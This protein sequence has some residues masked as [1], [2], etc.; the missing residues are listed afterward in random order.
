MPYFCLWV[1][2]PRN[3]QLQTDHGTCCFVLRGRQ[4]M[5]GGVRETSLYIYGALFRFLKMVEG[6]NSEQH[7]KIVVSLQTNKLEKTPIV[8]FTKR[9]KILHL[10]VSFLWSKHISSRLLGV[11]CVDRKLGCIGTQN[12]TWCF[13][14]H[15]L[16]LE[17]ILGHKNEL[18]LITPC[19]SLISEQRWWLKRTDKNKETKKVRERKRK[20]WNK[21]LGSQCRLRSC[22]EERFLLFHQPL[23]SQPQCLHSGLVYPPNC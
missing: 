20:E 10:C 15:D 9:K 12:S 6:L 3:L 14:E 23:M 19:F 18:L 1:P 11:W 2:Q 13:F 21:F 5:G 22:G 17:Y 16:R 4:G 8:I 7:V